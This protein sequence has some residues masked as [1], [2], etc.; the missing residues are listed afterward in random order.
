MATWK[1]RERIADSAI[2]DDVQ[3]QAAA[4]GQT[5]TDGKASKGEVTRAKLK[6]KVRGAAKNMS[7]VVKSPFDEERPKTGYENVPS[8]EEAWRPVDLFGNMPDL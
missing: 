1:Q 4:I 3:D 5:A 7:E 2:S 8:A 6:N